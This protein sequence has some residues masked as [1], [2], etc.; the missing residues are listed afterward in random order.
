VADGRLANATMEMGIG[1]EEP[2]HGRPGANA[3]RT[4]S[5]AGGVAFS[6]RSVMEVTWT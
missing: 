4:D 3:N 5:P 6:D 2:I 1:T